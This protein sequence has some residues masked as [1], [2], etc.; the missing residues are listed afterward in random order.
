MTDLAVRLKREPHAEIKGHQT[1]IM[2][3]LG[4][5]TSFKL[6]MVCNINS[7]GLGCSGSNKETSA[8][9]SFIIVSQSSMMKSG[10]PNLLNQGFSTCRH[11][12]KL[13]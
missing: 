9:W 5:M 8:S 12:I 7:D 6:I 1:E 10:N 3:L 11:R 2:T 4:I 13:L